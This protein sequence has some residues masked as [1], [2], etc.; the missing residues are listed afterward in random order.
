MPSQLVA[1]L[2]GCDYVIPDEA[3]L[4]LCANP[5]KAALSYMCVVLMVYETYGACVAFLALTLNNPF[6]LVG[7]I[8]GVV[9]HMEDTC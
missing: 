7:R 8:W 5:V 3:L 9:A 2:A 1:G 4:Q 6:A